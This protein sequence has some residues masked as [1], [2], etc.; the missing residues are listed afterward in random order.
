MASTAVRQ[1]I[2]PP[3]VEPTEVYRAGYESSPVKLRIAVGGAGQSG[4]IKALGNAFI[5]H[6]VKSCQVLS[7]GNAFIGKEVG[8]SKLEPFAV[9]WYASDT[10]QSFNYLAQNVVDMSVTYHEIA[11]QIAIK[12]GVADR[13]EYCFRDHWM[14]VGPKHN[15]AKLVAGPDTTVYDLLS[16]LFIAAITTQTSKDPIRFLS[17]YDKSAANI[18]ESNLWSAIGQTPWS[19]PYSHWYHRYVEFPFR[20]LN[21]AAQLEEY[22]LTDR[23]TWY[24]SEPWI[25]EK[26]TIFIEGGDSA[27]D[28]LLNPAHALVGTAV[29]NKDMANKFL[30]WIIGPEGQEVFKTF[31]VN[32][33][34]LYTPAPTSSSQI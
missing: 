18:K 9:A 30:D 10:T 1:D 33:V 3:Y 21:V 26:M 11:E 4:L 15:P 29:T 12:Q 23:G 7:L 8:E 19:Y 28:P 2:S 22:T 6:E 5:A 32:G 14:L 27:N 13:Y 16:Q 17:R 24:S 31:A 20:A 25:R 34:V